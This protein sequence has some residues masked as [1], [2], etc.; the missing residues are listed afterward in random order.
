MRAFGRRLPKPVEAGERA[1]QKNLRL[2]SEAH[3]SLQVWYQIGVKGK[4]GSRSYRGAQEKEEGQRREQP[5]GERERV[6]RVIFA[7][8]GKGRKG[9][10]LEQQ[11]T[12]KSKHFRQNA[13]WASNHQK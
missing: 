5:W 12:A 9:D 3:G 11:I 7:Q 6:L 13:F 2:V 8:Y 10:A 4:K 1:L